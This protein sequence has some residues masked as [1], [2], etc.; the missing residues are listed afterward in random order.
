MDFKRYLKPYSIKNIET[1]QILRQLFDSDNAKN[2][3]PGNGKF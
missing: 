1:K 2:F 3:S